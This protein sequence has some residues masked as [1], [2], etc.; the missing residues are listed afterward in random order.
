VTPSATPRK[1]L[2]QGREIVLHDILKPVRVEHVIHVPKHVADLGIPL[3]HRLEISEILSPQEQAAVF[4]A[5][6]FV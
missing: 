2:A 5:N 3:L 6:V 1:H 4:V